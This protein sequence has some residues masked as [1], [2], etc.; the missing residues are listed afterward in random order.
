MMTPDDMENLDGFGKRK[1]RIVY[2]AILSKLKDIPLSTLQHATGI[3]K[4]LGSKKLTLLEHFEHKP[5]LEEV[6]LIEG[7]AETSA[8]AYLD[9]YDRFF[10]YIEMLP[11][12]YTVPKVIVGGELEGKIFVFTGVRRKDLEDTITQMGGK[13][14]SS[15]SGK[16]THLIMKSKG[17]GSSKEKTALKLGV[18]IMTV[19]ELESMLK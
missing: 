15:V 19:E 9:G 12:T 10:E 1:A 6:L 11:V 5:S 3:F 4:G 16:T 7:F 14:G 13:V 17:S 8:Q 18:E 2:D